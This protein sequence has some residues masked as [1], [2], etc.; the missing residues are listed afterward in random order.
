MRSALE[1]SDRFKK[2][3]RIESDKANQ[4][5]NEVL[6]HTG[7]KSFTES[8]F[9]EKEPTDWMHTTGRNNY[10]G[11]IIILKKPFYASTSV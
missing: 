6:V 7:L 8:D 11:N 10:T 4:H 9:H 1:E 2:A 3:A 5:L